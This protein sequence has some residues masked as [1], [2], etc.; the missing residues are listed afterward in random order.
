MGVVINHISGQKGTVNF[1]LLER[2]RTGH[3]ITVKRNWQN[4]HSNQKA[5]HV[6]R[7]HS[8]P[9]SVNLILLS[10]CITTSM[11]IKKVVVTNGTMEAAETKEGYTRY[12][13]S[14][15]KKLCLQLTNRSY[16]IRENELGLS[17]PTVNADLGTC[18]TLGHFK[19]VK[20]PRVSLMNLHLIIVMCAISPH[21][22][23]VLS[24]YKIGNQVKNSLL[25][26]CC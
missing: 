6:P 16:L 10:R 13:P 20:T 12:V 17:L 26:G 23:L 7:Y 3:S 2:I 18:P 9:Y 24:L 8:Q 4:W 5:W 19:S 11:G 22:H 1:W 21:T 15:W 25:Y 14:N